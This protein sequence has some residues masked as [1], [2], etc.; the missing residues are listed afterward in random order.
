MEYRDDGYNQLPSKMF[1]DI[2]A[3]EELRGEEQPSEQIC[4]SYIYQRKFADSVYWIISISIIIFN[5]LFYVFTPPVVEIIRQNLKTDQTRTITIVITFCLLVDMIVLPMV[6]GMNLI[7]YTR[8]DDQEDVVE[9]TLKALGFLWGKHTDFGGSWYPDTGN[10]IMMTMII[11]S[12]QAIIDFIVEW[13]VIA[14]YRCYS[15]K[16]FWDREDKNNKSKQSM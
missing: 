9:D 16:F 6:I 13:I 4:K 5:S 3:R 10:M 8:F 11:F 7:E 14:I 1:D 2:A 12:I 15:R